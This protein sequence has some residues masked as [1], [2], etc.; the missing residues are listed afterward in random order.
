MSVTVRSN[1]N[2][3]FQCAFHVVWC[4]KYRRRVLGGRVAERLKQLIREVIEE[5]GAW[6][7]ALEVLPDQVHLLVEVDP[8]LGVHRLVKAVKGRTSRV[9]REEF[10]SLR[11]RLPTLWTNSYFVATTGGAPLAE[12][13]EYVAQQK[14]R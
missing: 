3:V 12:V 9:L 6:L 10:P 5:K 4:P 1:S 2:I 14:G 8:Q 11:S 7:T 13:E